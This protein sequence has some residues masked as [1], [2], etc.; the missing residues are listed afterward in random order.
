MNNDSPD[1]RSTKLTGSFVVDHNRR[2]P[3]LPADPPSGKSLDR[4][5][6]AVAH[7][8]TTASIISTLI[9]VYS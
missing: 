7:H 2:F 3:S 5:H 1:K 8:R 4:V 9:I 6:S